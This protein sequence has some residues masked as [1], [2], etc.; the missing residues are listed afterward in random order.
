MAQRI[1]DLRVALVGLLALGTG[2]ASVTRWIWPTLQVAPQLGGDAARGLFL[3]SLALAF[4]TYSLARTGR[5]LHSTWA[6]LSR[7]PSQALSQPI[8]YWLVDVALHVVAYI[9]GV[10]FLVCSLAR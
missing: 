3:L 2:V 6:I 1:R 7:N 8:R 10:A 5:W 4:S 9:A